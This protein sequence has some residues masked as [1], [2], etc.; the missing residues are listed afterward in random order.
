MN[1]LP[2]LETIVLDNDSGLRSIELSDDDV[3]AL[4]GLRSVSLRNVSGGLHLA[5]RVGSSV[6]TVLYSHEVAADTVLQA[7][8][9]PRVRYVSV[10]MAIVEGL[11]NWLQVLPKLTDLFILN[12]RNTERLSSLVASEGG[13]L[14]L[15]LYHIIYEI[16]CTFRK[17]APQQFA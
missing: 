1:K 14:T 4:R 10:H 13:N 7:V 15:E 6:D 2:S 3:E 11:N 8:N 5:S 16:E 17:G 9:C 12:V